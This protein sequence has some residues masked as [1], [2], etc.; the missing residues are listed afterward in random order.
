MTAGTVDWAHKQLALVVASLV[1]AQV[2]F[3]Q[4]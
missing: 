4:L 1:R 2:L 3:Q